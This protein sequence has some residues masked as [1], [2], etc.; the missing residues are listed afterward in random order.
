MIELG[1]HG[2]GT[3]GGRTKTEGV[4]PVGAAGLSTLWWSIVRKGRE[5][6]E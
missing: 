2:F 4:L 5:G 3:L 6:V 1:G